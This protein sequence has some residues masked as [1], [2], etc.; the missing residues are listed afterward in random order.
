MNKER[1]EIKCKK[2]FSPEFY[3]EWSGTGVPEKAKK[4]WSTWV[5]RVNW[6]HGQHIHPEANFY[7]INFPRENFRR[8]RRLSPKTINKIILIVYGGLALVATLS[9]VYAIL[10]KEVNPHNW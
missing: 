2:D 4:G 9:L 10:T 6:E 3:K 5:S 8:S 1:I 7:K